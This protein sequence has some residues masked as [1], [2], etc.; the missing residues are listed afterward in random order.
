ME[1]ARGAV[2]AN[3]ADA[4]A[5]AHSTVSPLVLNKTNRTFASKPTERHTCTLAE[6]HGS[7]THDASSTIVQSHNRTSTH[8]HALHTTTRPNHTSTGTHAAPPCRGSCIAQPKSASRHRFS[9][10]T[11]RLSGLTSR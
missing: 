8:P 4:D 9:L 2:P 3:T 10:L 7:D 1:S 5:P 6:P 11:S